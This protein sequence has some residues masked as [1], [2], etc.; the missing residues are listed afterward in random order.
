MVRRYRERFLAITEGRLRG[1]VW[2]EGCS[3]PRLQESGCSGVAAGEQVKEWTSPKRDATT[4]IEVSRVEI[5]AAALE[6]REKHAPTSE[7]RVCF[8]FVRFVLRR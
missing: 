6:R 1:V 8:R 5:K 3:T 7:L 2:Q 4:F